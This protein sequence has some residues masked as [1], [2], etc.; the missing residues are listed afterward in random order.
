MKNRFVHL[1]MALVA[2]VIV[3]LALVAMAVALL[4]LE[5]DFLWKIQELNLF[6][7][8]TMFLKQQMVVPG[9]FLSWLGCYF[10]QYL[11]YPWMGVVILVAWWALLI[12]VSAKAFKVPLKWLTVLLVPV[13]LL[14]CCNVMLDYWIYYLKLR[15]YFFV[16]SIGATAA[17]SLV[18]LY[19]LEPPRYFS[20]CI[21]MVLVTMIGYPLMG[22]YALFAVALM[23]L[24]SW[25]LTD[26]STTQ[27]VVATVVA[28][29]CIV[30]VPLIYYRQVY[31][32]TNILNIYWAA[33]PIFRLGKE[34][35]SYYMP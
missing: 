18:W 14:L 9:G 35:P 1:P 26:M 31:Y 23:A 19:R 28:V 32:Q 16:A 4:I 10:T 25:R 24:L 21:F 11:Y 34:L 33:L 3:A 17:I 22:I 13:V 12:Y 27:R 7:Y 29:V 30:L 15:G 8:S 20:R 6:L 2:L 5:S